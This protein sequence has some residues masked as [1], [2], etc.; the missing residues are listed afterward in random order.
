FILPSLSSTP[1]T[2][3]PAAA[4]YSDMVLTFSAGLLI[5]GVLMT[6]LVSVLLVSVCVSVSPTM[7]PV[8]ASLSHAEAPTPVP[9]NSLLL[10]ATD[11][12][13]PNFAS[14][15]SMASLALACCSTWLGLF[16][17]SLPLGLTKASSA[18]G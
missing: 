11:T 2:V 15:A 10:A 6:G 12:P 3:T 4:V 9:L 18:P 13:V 16:K 5:V 8:G 7:T 14:R 17:K 1:S